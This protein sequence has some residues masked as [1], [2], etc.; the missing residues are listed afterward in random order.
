MST[1]E[2]SEQLLPSTDDLMALLE[3][4]WDSFVSPMPLLPA[5]PAPAHDWSTS[6]SVDGAWSGRITLYLSDAGAQLIAG[7]MLASVIAADPAAPA[8][9]A[10]EDLRDAIGELANILGGNLKSLMPEPSVLSLPVVE[11]SP[12]APADDA[13]PRCR[14]DLAWQGEPVTV[15]VQLIASN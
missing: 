5:A 2:S 13:A 3:Q 9:L 12:A 7:R 11:H 8:A 15:H 14:L 10:E 1:L 4:M 6:V